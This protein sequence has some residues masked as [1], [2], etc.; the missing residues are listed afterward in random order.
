ME[1]EKIKN[2]FLIDVATHELTILKDDGG[3]HE[4]QRNV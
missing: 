4:L 2:A 3:Y 1:S